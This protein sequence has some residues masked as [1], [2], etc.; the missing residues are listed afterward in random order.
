MNRYLLSG[1]G[2]W[3][4]LVISHS[5]IRWIW[6]LIW[7]IWLWKQNHR[8]F[9]LFLLS[10]VLIQLKLLIPSSMPQTELVGK[11][12]TIR[13]HSF[14]LR[15]NQKDIWINSDDEVLLDD[16]VSVSC[17]LRPIVSTQNRVGYSFEQW[18]KHHNIHYQCTASRIDVIKQGKSLRRWV[19]L[20]VREMPE[21]TKEILKMF[22]FHIYDAKVD[23]L[24]L[25][26][27][28]GIH[29]SYGLKMIK[30]VCSYFFTEKRV[31]QIMYG[32]DIF[33]A[34]FY[35]FSFLSVR[36]LIR[37]GLKFSSLDCQ[38]QW[39]L[40]ICILTCLFPTYITELKFLIPLGIA[41]FQCFGKK[42][43]SMVIYLY[44]S[45][46]Q[47][48]KQ[49]FLSLNNIVYM[50]VMRPI[51]SWIFCICILRLWLPIDGI[52]PYLYSFIQW[53]Q[54]D[55]SMFS[56]EL[57]GK[58]NLFCVIL[59]FVL[60]VQY[61]TFHKKK[62]LSFVLLC[63]LMNQKQ[64]ILLPYARVH[65]LDVGQGDCTLISLPFGKG[66]I[67]IDTGGSVSSDVAKEIVVPVLKSYG[68]SSLDLVL[69]THDD[70]DHSGAYGSLI[71][72]IPIKETIV[73]KQKE[74]TVGAFRIF[75]GLYHQRY[76]DS[77]ANS[78]TAC[79]ELYGVR[80]LFLGDCGMQQEKE[81]VKQYQNLT[82]DVLKVA[83]HGSKTSTSNKLLE[84]IKP[85]MAIISVGAYNRYH[86]PSEEVLLRLDQYQIPYWQ[87]KNEKAITVIVTPW[88]YWMKSESGK[89]RLYW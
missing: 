6:L 85:E 77:N 31:Q 48:M 23:W 24:F 25:C 75:D 38:D 60:L 47:L 46:L 58:P 81:I 62:Y 40:M 44:I 7:G 32:C 18:A 45:L 36:Y 30:K 11:V 42:R 79:F 3:I 59:I 73:E 35:H 33:L 43:S 2:L 5:W 28:L 15:V 29:L 39:G 74:Y 71:K 12:V 84:S 61:Q 55:I 87:T 72:L 37:D 76:E 64:N 14:I 4:F 34:I 13:K 1:M 89:I 86:H 88:M 51:F 10:I 68:I 80:F 20:K 54:Q 21:E 22:L 19:Q 41:F 83:H 17:K 53:I 56:L 78:L 26:L 82:V 69:L 70:L 63:L 65:Y 49:G 9:Y 8:C 16:Q 27:S 57:I 50:I 52:F 67:L 66:N